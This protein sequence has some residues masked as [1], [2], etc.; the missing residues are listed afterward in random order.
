MLQ[1]NGRTYWTVR[2]IASKAG[3]TPQTVYGWLRGLGVPRR[4]ESVQFQGKHHIADEEWQ[5]FAASV[6]DKPAQD[7]LS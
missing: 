1:V 5:D 6:R 4:L 3:V 7:G 2:E